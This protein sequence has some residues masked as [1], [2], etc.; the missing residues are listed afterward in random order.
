MSNKIL[1]FEQVIIRDVLQLFETKKYIKHNVTEE[2]KMSLESLKRN[3][4]IVIKPADKGGSFVRIT[5]TILPR[6]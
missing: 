2:E 4:N 5:K 6:L 1:A 3:A